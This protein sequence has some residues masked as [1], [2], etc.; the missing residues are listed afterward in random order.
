MRA[1]AKILCI[2]AHHIILRRQK[3][4]VAGAL[5]NV[6]WRQHSRAAPLRRIVEHAVIGLE[7]HVLRRNGRHHPGLRAII[8]L[9]IG[10][11]ACRGPIEAR[12]IEVIKKRRRHQMCLFKPAKFF[13]MRAIG[14]KA[15]RVVFHGAQNQ[16]VD[17]IEH[18]VGRREVS[19]LLRRRMHRFSAQAHHARAA[20]R[21]ALHLNVAE[22]VIAEARMPGFNA[23][24]GAHTAQ[25]V[26]KPL[27]TA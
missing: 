9:R 3:R 22:S 23:L 15:H 14:K 21:S 6:P 27:R 1:R 4:A 13:A 8:E 11:V 20:F 25:R 19:Y 24:P 12:K 26:R 10:D 2:R 7:D 5:V 18:L 16:H 17:A